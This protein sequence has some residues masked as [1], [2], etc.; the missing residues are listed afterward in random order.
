MFLEA[1]I[2]VGQN[3]QR[4]TTDEIL[5]VIWSDPFVQDYIVELNTNQQLKQGKLGNGGDMPEA[6]ESWLNF[7]K[8][9]KGADNFPSDKVNL[10][11]S[12]EFFDTFDIEVLNNGFLIVANTAIYGRDFQTIYG[13]DILGLNEEN[14]QKLINFIREDYQEELARRLLE[15]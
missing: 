8:A 4:L 3:A 10:F 15:M 7:K 1:M 6:G 9:V 13:F 14:L 2:K 12:G 11:F 5:K